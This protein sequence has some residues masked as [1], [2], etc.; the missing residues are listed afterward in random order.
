MPKFSIITVA[1]NSAKTIRQTIE[2]V[3]GQTYTDLEYIIVD[4]LS[5]DGTAAIAREYAPGFADKGM[6]Y[7]VISEKDSGIFDAMNK[8]IRLASGELVGLINSDDWYEPYALE[9]VTRAYETVPFDVF[10]ASLRLHIRD[11]TLIKRSKW[12]RLPSTR[13]WNHPTTFIRKSV[14]EVHKYA[15]KNDYDDWDLML[16]LRKQGYCFVIGEEVL[17][18]FRYGGLSTKKDITRIPKRIA[19]RYEIYRA[20]GYSRLYWLECVAVELAKYIISQ[21]SCGF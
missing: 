11:R 19:D 20:N 17:A 9:T 1:Y 10:Y 4:G 2:S 7:R 13:N 16:R 14:Y 3:L 6:P 21:G 15:C 18:N 8:G 5:G 12:D